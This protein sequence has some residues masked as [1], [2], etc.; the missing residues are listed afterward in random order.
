MKST[1]AIPYLIAALEDEIPGVRF[2]AGLALANIGLPA[3]DALIESLQ[4]DNP[5]VQ[6]I[7]ASALGDIG[8]EKDQKAA[9]KEK[10][11]RELIKALDKTA[12]P[13]VKLTI[14]DA[15]GKIG[16]EYA[17]NVLEQT[18]ESTTDVGLKVFIE[19]LLKSM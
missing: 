12:E 11:R 13:T 19:E 10:I 2:K 18:Q 8:G 4:H 3:V 16:G 9:I 6:N 5:S 14:A 7:A 15:L 1:K 17:L